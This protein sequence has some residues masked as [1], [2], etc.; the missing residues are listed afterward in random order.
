MTTYKTR[1]KSGDPVL[2]YNPKTIAKVKS[3][4]DAFIGR[5]LKIGKG[6]YH[7]VGNDGEEVKLRRCEF[8]ILSGDTKDIA[9]T[10]CLN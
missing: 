1:G 7:I 5:I 3:D 9:I 8:E 6:L 2:V 10:P 4:P